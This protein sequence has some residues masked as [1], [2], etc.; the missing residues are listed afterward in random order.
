MA[1]PQRQPGR[2][3]GGRPPPDAPRMPPGTNP[4]NPSHAANP[5]NPGNSAN[6]PNPAAWGQPAPRPSPY[7]AASAGTAYYPP[8]P[9]TVPP[10]A[11]RPDG[12][13]PEHPPLR[14]PVRPPVTPA[15]QRPRPPA[16][17]VNR[18]A[19]R[20]GAPM[21]NGATPAAAGPASARPRKPTVVRGVRSRRLVRRFDVLS[22]FRVSMIF[23]ICVFVVILVAGIGLWNVAA[24]F[25]VITDLDK[26]VRSLFALNAFRLHPLNALLWGAIIA[27]AACFLGVVFNVFV[28]VIYNLISDVV[29]GVQVI[30]VSD[31]GA[32]DS[33]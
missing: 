22:V 30:V 17:P 33:V 5:A 14:P 21:P 6:P 29:G 19:V 4:A 20:P 23:Y 8:E 3:G 9:T 31:Q 12:R 10:P 28:A 2:Q 27:G 11:R 24:A 7:A 25:G 32:E 26:L 18:D 1:D 13:A 15:A 16:G